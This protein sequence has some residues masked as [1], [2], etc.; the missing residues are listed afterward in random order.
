MSLTAEIAQHYL[1]II[2]LLDGQ[3][4]L[5][6]PLT[7][8]SWLRLSATP[9]YLF[10]SFFALFRFHPLTLNYLWMITS[11]LLIPL[12]YFVVK[13]VFDKKTAMFSSLLLVVSP[14]FLG[15]LKL[16][17]FFNFI[18]PLFYFLLLSIRSKKIWLV[19]LIISFMSNLHT[20][21]FMLLP[22]FI[23]IFLI[24]KRFNI[25]QAIFSFIAFLIPQLSFIINDFFSNFSM[26]KNLLLWIPYKLINFITGKT[27]GL[28]S[29]PVPDETLKNIFDFI[30]L[31]FLP[32]NFHWSL[33][34][35]ILFMIFFYFRKRKTLFIEK[36]L[37]LWLIFRLVIL[38]IHKN[39]PLH[40]FMPLYFIPLILFS[41]ILT[42]INQSLAKSIILLF[43]IVNIFFIF[44]KTKL[45]EEFIPY[46]KE[47]KIA[48]SIIQNARGRKF[49]LSRQGPFDN[50]TDQ[51]KQNYEFILWWLG[52]RPVKNAKLNY[53][54]VE[55]KSSIRVFQGKNLIYQIR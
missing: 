11:V 47:E 29:K 45:S 23:G 3:W 21:A 12:N 41:R 25:K 27:L 14:L 48:R 31:N 5:Q 26:T 28:N 20:A 43:L 22:F 16:P 34:V 9:Y 54:I 38:M 53:L 35:L 7:S 24:I 1:E 4:L 46:E 55:N 37:F 10:F 42:L 6:G 13:K 30:K 49:S 36:V 39:P 40:Y 51:F 8:H 17:S 19:F 15:L 50:Y 18:S 52:N 44:Q 33:G 2:K 32:V